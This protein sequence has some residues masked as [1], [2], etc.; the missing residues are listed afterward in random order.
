MAY[1]TILVHM[2]DP[3]RNGFAALLCHASRP[4]LRRSP[5]RS[6]RL[7]RPWRRAGHAASG[8]GNRRERGA[9]SSG[10]H[11]PGPHREGTIHQRSVSFGHSDPAKIVV[12]RARTADLVV[13]NQA[14]R[15]AT[16]ALFDA[17]PLLKGARKVEL[18][19]IHEATDN[20]ILNA[21]ED[22]VP[23]SA[24]ADALQ[25]MGVKPIVNSLKATGG[26]AGEQICAHAIGQQADLLVM[27][28]YGRA[29]ARI[30]L[31]RHH[32]LRARE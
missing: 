2:N 20:T 27:G 25:A 23:H 24:I 29:A 8:R 3:R 5:D 30:R 31:R 9:S 21:D 17:L 7:S 14:D 22:V 11:L 26:T 18:L 15:E 16:R 1:R 19:S 32:A 4:A 6:A 28:A 13:V 10:V 12:A